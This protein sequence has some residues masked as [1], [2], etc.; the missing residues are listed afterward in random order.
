MVTRRDYTAEAVEAAKSVLIELMHLLG[1][2]RDDIVLIGGWVPELLLP[3][4]PRPH[5]GSMDID[6]ALNH[7]KIQD[8]YKRIEELLLGRGYYQEEGRQPF[9][10]F[11]DVPVNGK[12]VKVQVD[13]LSG[14]YEGTGKGR[15][16][17]VIQEVKARKVR[18]CDIAFDMVKEI[19]VEGEIP[20]GGHDRVTIR[21]ASIVP[22]FVMKGMAL[23]ERLKEKDAWDIYYCIQAYP[24]GIEALAEEFRPHLSHGLVQEGLAK[25]AKHFADIKSIGPKFVVDFEDTDDP[26]EVERITRDAFERV[27]AFLVKLGIAALRTFPE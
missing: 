3:Q 10:F 22:F 26:D 14:E 2:Y 21:V 19:S 27:H 4:E 6:L 12:T 7:Q 17:Q 16:H 25:I 20:G 23:D 1:E 8:G 13:L 15:R 24:G 9:I 11:R 18:G 5:V